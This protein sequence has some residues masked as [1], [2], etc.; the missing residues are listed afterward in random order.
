MAQGTASQRARPGIAV[1]RQPLDLPSIAR[2][3]TPAVGEEFTQS[4]N[5]LPSRSMCRIGAASSITQDDSRPIS[6]HEA[7]SGSWS[8]SE[9]P[10]EPA[11][12]SQ[13]H[14]EHG[15]LV[16]SWATVQGPRD[17]WRWPASLETAMLGRAAWGG[18]VDRPAL[19]G[20]PMALLIGALGGPVPGRSGRHLAVT[21]SPGLGPPSTPAHSVTHRGFAMSRALPAIRAPG[22]PRRRC[23]RGHP[24][25][26]EL[27]H[28][29]HMR[30]AGVELRGSGGR[31][32][33]ALGSGVFPVA[34]VDGRTDFG[35]TCSSLPGSRGCVVSR[36]VTAWFGG[37]L[38]T[39][40]H[41]RDPQ[42]AHC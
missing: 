19:D 5:R 14:D 29:K 11:L 41:E 36:R 25:S 8:T 7:T 31:G 18:R 34:S 15:P 30:A 23:R 40:Q 24:A 6:G 10:R 38:G 4:A 35:S 28:W 20:S 22:S 37:S 3:M 16:S 42:R 21:F 17:E 2:R 27:D 12:F 1:P 32:G 9:Q 39:G 26:R 13:F 33:C